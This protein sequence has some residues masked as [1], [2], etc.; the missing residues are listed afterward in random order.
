MSMA[1]LNRMAIF[2]MVKD[3]NIVHIPV[4][5]ITKIPSV[6]PAQISR[7]IMLISKNV[8]SALI[9]TRSLK[10]ITVKHVLITNFGI[11]F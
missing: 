11:R 6:K 3:V 2:G 10:G 1:V 4:T 9:P 5:G 7:F 8:I